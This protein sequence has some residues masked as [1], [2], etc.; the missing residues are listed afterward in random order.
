MPLSAANVLPDVVRTGVAA[1]PALHGL[2]C[3]TVVIAV[4]SRWTS[5]G[6]KQ[7]WQGVDWHTAQMGPRVI[8]V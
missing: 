3:P 8:I 7:A 1:K 5:R 6:A 4:S 2:L